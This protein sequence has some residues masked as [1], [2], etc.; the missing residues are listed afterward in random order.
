MTSN[1]TDNS[2]F[3]RW[4]AP[5]VPNEAIIIL[6]LKKT[7]NKDFHSVKFIC[8]LQ[9]KHPSSISVEIFFIFLLFIL[10]ETENENQKAL[11][12]SLSST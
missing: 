10:F 7:Q 4:K 8:N 6:L 9:T 12:A 2:Y 3:D 11:E 1:L 5:Y